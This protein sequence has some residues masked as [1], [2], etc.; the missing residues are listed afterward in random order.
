VAVIALVIFFVVL[1]TGG[2]HHLSSKGGGSTTTATSPKKGG[3]GSVIDP[4]H[5]RTF[6]GHYGEE[7]SW[8]I[9]ENKLPGTKAWH[10]WWTPRNGY[11]QG[12]ANLTYAAVGQKVNLY[13]ST[14]APR[15]SIAAY[16]MGYYG[17]DGGRLVWTSREETG[18]IQ[19]SCPL[20]TGINMVSC[21]NWKPS[22][23]LQITK[24]FLPGDYLLKLTGSGHEQS[25]IMLTV[26]DP[27]SH[28]AYV[29]MGSTFTEAAWN[30]Y[31]GYDFYQGIGACPADVYPVCNRARVVSLDRPFASGNG[32]SDFFTNEYPV[33]SFAEEHG[34]DV[35]YATDLTIDEHPAYLLEHR[36][37]LSLGHDECWSLSERQSAQNA[38]NH[39]VNMIFFGAS[40]VL[41]HV[42]LQASTLGPDREVVDYR[43]PTEDPL[44]GKASPLEVTANTW[45]SPPT[46]WPESGFVGEMYAGY[47]EPG[48]AGAPFVVQDAKAWIFRGTGL[49]DG[50]ALPGVIEADFD[51]VSADFPMP[52][53]VQVLGH[54]PIPLANVQTDLGQWGQYTY[55]DMTYYTSPTSKAGVFDSGNNNWIAAMTPCKLHTRGCTANQVRRITSNVFWLFGQGPAGRFIPSVS[56]LSQVLPA[57]S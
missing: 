51:H 55:S 43:D 53:D 12:F 10:I 9:A 29:I 50:S 13:V 36:A 27:S 34:L 8:V 45:G 46:D 19:P 31:G 5:S 6:L 28:A 47:L 17:G 33:I 44:N 23:S 56:N 52:S 21:D 11:I 1:G 14:S 24:A 3:G 32:A 42:R 37:L 41:R 22:L 26:W 57:G 7:A 20:T 25:Y 2:D 49:H 18:D 40:A 35:T 54:S 16:R 38:L 30:T 4:E 48:T 15:Y 39:G